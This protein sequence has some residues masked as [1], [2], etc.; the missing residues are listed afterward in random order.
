MTGRSHTRF[1]WILAAALI[2]LLVP[3]TTLS[4]QDNGV[5]QDGQGMYGEL[6]AQWWQWILEQPATGNPNLDTTGADAANGQPREDISFLAGAFGGEYSRTFNAPA[7]TALFLPLL[8]NLG[9]AA[10]PAPQPK[11]GG[12][13][14]PQLRTLIALS[15]VTELHVTLDGVS[16]RDSV[17]RVKSPVFHFTAPD[18]DGLVDPGRYTALS[19]GYWLFLAPLAA[20]THV[21]NFGGTVGSFTVD[22]TDTITVK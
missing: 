3:V 10:M 20:G 17:A 4:A 19:D 1:A 8:N 13:Q 9:F 7:N 11:L 5:R 18:V 16:L 21:L 12:N 15:E 6:T 22:I 2:G 14:V